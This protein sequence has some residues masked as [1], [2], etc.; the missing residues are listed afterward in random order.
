MSVYFISDLHLGHNH[1]HVFGHRPWADSPELHDLILIDRINDTVNKRDK[2]FILGDVA[3]SK[4]GAAKLAD[5]RCKNIEV[6][7]GNHDIPRYIMPYIHRSHGFFKYNGYWV[8]HCPMHPIELRGMQN[9]HGHVHHNVLADDRY[10]SVCVDSC[11][12][13]P[14]LFED[15]LHGTY[16]THEGIV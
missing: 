3:W 12:G 11:N 9:I 13:Y 7:W 6:V 4:P 16:T 8:S 1:I 15:I 5:I 10:V 14:V 2:L